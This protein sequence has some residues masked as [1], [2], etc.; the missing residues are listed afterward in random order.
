M[1]PNDP[2]PIFR[3]SRYLLPTLNSMAD[4]WDIGQEDDV[5]AC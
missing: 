1:S 2:D 5:E 3:P 4:Y